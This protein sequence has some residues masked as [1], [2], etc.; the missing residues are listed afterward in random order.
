MYFGLA[1][2][3]IESGAAEE[4]QFAVAFKT[5]SPLALVV[6]SALVVLNLAALMVEASAEAACKRYFSQFWNVADL[7]ITLV[8][9]FQLF[10]EGNDEWCGRFVFGARRQR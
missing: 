6:M 7:V 2:L 5:V 8:M 1:Y 4:N 3:L 9:W 10:S